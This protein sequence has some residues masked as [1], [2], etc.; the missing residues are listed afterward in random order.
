MSQRRVD[1]AYEELK[2]AIEED[3]ME[4]HECDHSDCADCDN[5]DK[6]D[7]SEADHSE[8]YTSS[9]VCDER[10]EAIDANDK[11]WEEAIR[12]LIGDIPQ[13][14]MEQVKERLEDML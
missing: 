4:N 3:A 8:C 2:E 12:N 6:V 13:L 7:P 5:C 1:K 11:E 14:T 10:L 9:Q